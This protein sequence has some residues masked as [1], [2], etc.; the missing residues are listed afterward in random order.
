MEKQNKILLLSNIVLVGF[1]AAIF[2]HYV[3]GG[4]MHL[5]YPY[6]NFLFPPSISFSDFLDLLPHLT[7]LNPYSPPGDWQNY[8]PLTFILIYPF[9]FLKPALTAY[10]IF[11][12]VLGA[13]F[14]VLNF[15]NIKC[16]KFNFFQNFQ[17]FFIL[18]FAS[19]P[20][21][22]LFD[23]GNVDMLIFPLF[24]AFV[25]A[26]KKDKFVLGAVI[27]AVINSM[28]PFSL[29][30]LL[31]F[32]F[33]KKFKEF[34]LCG[35]INALLVFG[36]FMFFK[37]TMLDQMNI[38]MQS[39]IYMKKSFILSTN[40]MGMFGESSMFMPLKLLF[41]KMGL[42]FSISTVKFAGFYNWFSI[43]MTA[44]TAVLVYREK[45]FWKQI[46]FLT[47]YMVLVPMISMDYKLVFLYVPIWLF[48]NT[49]EKTRFDIFYVILLGLL[50]IPKNIIFLLSQTEWFSLSIILNPI[51][52]ALIFGL[53]TVQQFTKEKK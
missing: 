31:L 18:T 10:I 37:G 41:C 30:F 43:A 15:M 49:K 4:M 40:S 47:V 34:F 12:G 21:I 20:L 16:E 45:I 46:M 24:A 44:L 28:K 9:A 53:L 5:S 22:C 6:D 27:L 50:F 39:W 35:I 29:L 38:L 8:F 19:Y 1:I 52:L 3:L 25:Y 51:I 32:L 33:K 26:L 48:L 13:V 42:P 14:C 17:N 11:G 7:G 2:Y 23:R 36:G